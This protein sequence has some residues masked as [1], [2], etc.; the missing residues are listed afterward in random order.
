MINFLKSYMGN[1]QDAH[2]SKGNNID[3]TNTVGFALNGLRVKHVPG[4][5]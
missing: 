5:K 1:S 2:D 3:S 4:N